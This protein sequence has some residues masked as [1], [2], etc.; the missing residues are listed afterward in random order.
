MPFLDWLQHSAFSTW[1]VGSD[2]IWAY[3]SI[4]TAHTVGLA[5]LVGA[6]A[7]LDV[8][9]LGIAS[10]VPLE[11]LERLYSFIWAGFFINLASGLVLFVTEAADK[12]T[13]PVFLL[14]LALVFAALLVTRRIRTET[15]GAKASVDAR[16]RV[17]LLAVSSLFLWAAAITAGRLMAYFPR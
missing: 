5:I 8:R 4:L 12:A 9:L 6:A 3:P 2:S 16:G 10:D 15:F 1:I 17:K 11:Q 13:H 7:M 14:K